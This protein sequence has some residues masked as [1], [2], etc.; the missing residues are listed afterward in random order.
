MILPNIELDEYKKYFNYYNFNEYF[1]EKTFL[2]TGSKGIVG[3]GIIKWILLCNKLF[4]TNTHIIASTRNSKNIPSYIESTDNIE[5][6]DFGNEKEYCKDKEVD[7]IIHSA[8]P[9]SNKVFLSEP[10][11]SLNVIIDGT[12]NMLSIAREHNESSMIYISS[13]EVYGTHNVDNLI[14]E[15]YWGGVDSLSIRSCY[16]MGKKVSELLCKSY[17]E[18]YGVNVKIIRPTVILGLFQPYDSVKV[19]AE[20][21]RCILE[22]KNLFMKS[23]GLTKKSVIYSLDAVT[24]IFTVLFKGV[25]GEAYNATNPDTFSSVKD[26]AY[27]AFEKFNPNITIEFAQIDNSMASGYLPQRSVLE[28]ISKIKSLGWK[29]KTDMEE[30]YRID[31]Y[32]FKNED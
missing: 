8:A 9:T 24:A 10:V 32:R 3:T 29:P 4:G 17:F 12:K 14:Y 15:N 25:G 30:I 19:E 20:I 18:E 26:R 7:Y 16:P 28:D 6:C 2:I 13:E 21:L 1:K 23:A 31:I 11:E 27:W 22:N 5:Y